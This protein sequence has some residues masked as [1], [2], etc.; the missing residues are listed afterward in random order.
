MGRFDPT[1]EMEPEVKKSNSPSEHEHN[2]QGRETLRKGKSLKR[3]NSDS[4]PSAVNDRKRKLPGDNQRE[5]TFSTAKTEGEIELECMN[6]EQNE[7]V[8]DSSGSGKSNSSS[9]V[10]ST[11]DESSSSA[12]SS[13]ESDEDEDKEGDGDEEKPVMKVIAPEQKYMSNAGTRRKL[14]NISDEGMDD[15]DFDQSEGSFA[16]NSNGNKKCNREVE[17]ALRLSKIHI[18][19]AAKLWNLAPFLLENLQQDAYENFFPIQALVIPDVI[20]SERHAHIQNRDICVSAPTGSGKTLA[21]VLPVLNS[22]ARRRIRR[23]RAL[24]VLP[25][26]DLGEFFISIYIFCCPSCGV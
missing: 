25:S 12:P 22:L 15:F 5:E 3:K 14:Q 4:P 23:L 19:D 18:Q 6:A 13:D 8:N 7:D 24:V 21:F 1:M 26:R 17:T 9:S 20:A 10:P 16:T 2:Y 11:E